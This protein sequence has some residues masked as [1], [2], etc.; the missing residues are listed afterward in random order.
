[1]RFKFGYR[2]GPA[3]A[4]TAAAAAIFRLISLPKRRAV[5][6][7]GSSVA[8]LGVAAALYCL[9]MQAAPAYAENGTVSEKIS[10]KTSDGVT[11]VGTFYRPKQLRMKKVPVVILLHML[12][13]SRADWAGF[14]EELTGEGYCALA[15]D[16]R[17]HGESTRFENAIRNWGD[18]SESDYRA[19]TRDVTGALAWLKSRPEANT[20]RIALIGASIGANVALISA[21]NEKTVRTVVLLSPGLNYRGLETAY[22]AEHYG[23]RA[24]L[25]AGSEADEPGGADARSL[26]DIISKVASPAKIKMYQG[27]IHGSDLLNNGAGLDM[28]ILAWLGNNLMF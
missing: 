4:I 20:D 27:G 8:A 7:A 11:I 13:R 23:T 1:V 21:Q 25:I 28:I 10:Y 17:G 19:M 26:Y 12:S 6:F 2:R 24:V 9:F 5:G 16:L 22:A 3:A 14:A 18:F 15:I